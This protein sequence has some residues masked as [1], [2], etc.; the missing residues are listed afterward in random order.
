MKGATCVDGAADTDIP[1]DTPC[2]HKTPEP[3]RLRPVNCCRVSF[4]RGS[5]APGIAQAKNVKIRV[6]L[7]HDIL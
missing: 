5:D 7:A 3:A 1:F 6:P 2:P 4:D